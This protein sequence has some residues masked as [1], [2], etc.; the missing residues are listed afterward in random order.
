MKIFNIVLAL[1][2]ILHAIDLCADEGDTL[3]IQTF[4][5][6]N[7]SPEGWSAPYRGITICYP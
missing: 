5:W 2:F 6:D 4:S 3:I 7:P 1:L